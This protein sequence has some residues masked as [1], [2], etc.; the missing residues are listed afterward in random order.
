MH[1]F[2]V[3]RRRMVREQIADAGITDP[4]VQDA[5]RKVPR[6][7]FVPAA[8][9]RRAHQPCALPIGYGQTISK[10]F[11]VGLM[12]ALI[13]LQGHEKVLEVGTGSGYQGAILAYL[14]REVISVERV[15]PLAAQAAGIL[16]KLGLH[17]IRVLAHDGTIGYPDEAPYD[18][19]LVTACAP[20][21]P[22][23]LVSQLKDGGYLLIPISRGQEQILYR[24]RRQGEEVLIEQSV[25]CRFVPMLTGLHHGSD[26]GP[27]A[28]DE[29]KDD[30]NPGDHIA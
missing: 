2:A 1:E 9:S 10:P 14:A 3:A 6:H 15:A 12:S 5:M 24:Y 13:G 27:A 8:L 28:E 4:R 22:T 29:E 18:A 19:I 26:Q 30:P 25:S 7:L 20:Q 23:P 11:T 17:N 21:L 16:D